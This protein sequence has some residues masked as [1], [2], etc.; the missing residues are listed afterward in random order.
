M[1]DPILYSL[2]ARGVATLTLNRPELHNAFDDEIIACLTGQLEAIEQDPAVRVLVLTGNGISFSAGADLN[3]MRR[4]AGYSH[5]QNQRDAEGLA[6]LMQR[7]DTLRVPVV[8]RV[9]GSAFGGGAGLVWLRLRLQSVV[10]K[11]H[12]GLPQVALQALD[13]LRRRRC[14]NDMATPVAQQ[15]RCGLALL[16][17]VLHDHDESA[18][19]HRQRRIGARRGQQIGRSGSQRHFHAEAAAPA[20]P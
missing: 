18:V 15:Q 13:R 11:Q 16:L 4:M 1:S 7:L 17:L 2:D 6:R 14:R 9:Q 10:H 12:V 8:A 19:Q 5:E 3:W 20:Q